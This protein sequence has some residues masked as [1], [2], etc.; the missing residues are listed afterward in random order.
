VYRPENCAVEEVERC[1]LSR[2]QR[3]G[4]CGHRYEVAV[5][6]YRTRWVHAPRADSRPAGCDPFR[7]SGRV[8]VHAAVPTT[9]NLTGSANWEWITLTYLKNWVPTSHTIYKSAGDGPSRSGA[10]LKVPNTRVIVALASS[11]PFEL[12]VKFNGRSTGTINSVPAA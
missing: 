1:G 9:G 12:T 8:A 5:Q 4:V 2:F 3:Q 10:L 11:V 6:G 7:R